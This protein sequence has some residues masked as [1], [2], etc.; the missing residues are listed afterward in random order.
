MQTRLAAM[1]GFPTTTLTLA[2]HQCLLV[3][4][5][6]SATAAAGAE[7]TGGACHGKHS[8][9]YV[10]V[11]TC[12]ASTSWSIE[13]YATHDIRLQ[14]MTPAHQHVLATGTQDGRLLFLLHQQRYGTSCCARRAADRSPPAAS[15]GTQHTPSA[16]QAHAVHDHESEKSSPAAASLIHAYTVCTDSADRNSCAFSTLHKEPKSTPDAD[17]PAT[18]SGRL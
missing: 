5:A 3:A 12:V 6:Y 17:R 11:T 1:H 14:E 9:S 13:S 8:K 15:W 7:G 10:C 2:C 16:W 18:P 4:N